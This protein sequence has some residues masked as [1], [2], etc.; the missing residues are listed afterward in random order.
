MT[1]VKTKEELMEDAKACCRSL[2]MHLDAV[3]KA[4]EKSATVQQLGGY[5]LPLEI[6]GMGLALKQ[7]AGHIGKL[8]PYNDYRGLP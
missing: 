5:G 1:I 3:D 2:R 7:L 8:D 6:G 4:L